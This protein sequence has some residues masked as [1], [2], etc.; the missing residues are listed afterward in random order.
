VFE[1][2]KAT[3]KTQKAK[4]SF[5]RFVQGSDDESKLVESM[6]QLIRFVNL[7]QACQ[8]YSRKSL[9]INGVLSLKYWARRESQ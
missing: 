5:S 3:V 8:R 7:L 2:A 1:D 6:G 4:A 9:H